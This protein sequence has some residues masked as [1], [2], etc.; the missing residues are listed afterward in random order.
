MFDRLTMV[1][2]TDKEEP[3]TVSSVL[4]RISMWGNSKPAW[5]PDG[6]CFLL[7]LPHEVLERILLLA[8]NGSILNAIQV[9]H[10][11]HDLRGVRP[12]AR[13]AAR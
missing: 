1:L 9:S 6:P 10:A 4:D 12:D 2:P 3:S 8:D 7:G 5:E 11:A 13:P